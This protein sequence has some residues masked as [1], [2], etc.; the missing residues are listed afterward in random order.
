MIHFLGKK[1]DLMD[2][3]VDDFFEKSFLLSDLDENTLSSIKKTLH[4]DVLEFEPGDLIYSDERFDKSVGFVLKGECT[5]ERPKSDGQA[6]I[7]NILSDFDSFGILAVFSCEEKFPTQIRA[8]KKSRVLFLSKDGV[9]GL[10][11]KSPQIA[12][13]IIKFMSNKIS[14]LNDK[15][16]TFSSDNVEQKT[17][18]ELLLMHRKNNGQ[19]FALNCKKTAESLNYG[20][21]SLYRAIEALESKGIIKYENKIITILDLIGLERIAK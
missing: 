2:T 8:K 12:L 5:V 4:F 3:N 13:N 18:N 21:A 11:Q 9:V 17:A 7:L 6:L 10:I 14:F 1:G 15:I 19:S 16:L 20:R